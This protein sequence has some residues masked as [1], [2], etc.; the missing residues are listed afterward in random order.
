MTVVESRFSGGPI[1]ID[2]TV[3]WLDS[4]RRLVTIDAPGF[5][6]GLFPHEARELAQALQDA[7][8]EAEKRTVRLRRPRA[9][10][11]HLQV[12]DD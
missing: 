9:V 6:T 4:T 10:D 5:G 1:I 3:D 11:E 8:A 2:H 12:L 7:A